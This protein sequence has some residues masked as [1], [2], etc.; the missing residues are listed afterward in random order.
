MDVGAA[1]NDDEAPA[2]L[3]SDARNGF[4]EGGYMLSWP[5]PEPAP[6]N[7]RPPSRRLDEGVLPNADPSIASDG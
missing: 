2:S 1:P 4:D 5:D 6:A 3:P 7:P